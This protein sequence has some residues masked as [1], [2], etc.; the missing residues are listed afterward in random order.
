[1]PTNTTNRRGKWLTRPVFML[2]AGLGFLWSAWLSTR[3]LPPKITDGTRSIRPGVA[4]RT[5]IDKTGPWRIQIVEI[6]LKQPDLHIESARATDYFYGR[7]KLTSI[8]RRKSDNTRYVVVALNGDYFNLETGE[9]QNNNIIGGTFVKAFASPGYHPE[10]V[11]VPNSQFA[12]TRD[13]RP[14]IDQFVFSGRVLW[15]DGTA[16]QLSGVNTIPRRG[17]ISLFN[18]FTDGATP[19]ASEDTSVAGIRLQIVRRR[20]DTLICVGIGSIQQGGNLPIPSRGMVLAAYK[21]WRANLDTSYS[22]GDSVRIVLGM[23]PGGKDISE[24]I[25]GWPRIVRNGKSVFEMAGFPEN[26]DAS[27]FVKRHPRSG[28]GF[29]RDSTVL[30]LFAVDGRQESSAGMSLPEFARLMISV[31]VYEG[32]NLDGGGSTT[33]VIN[34]DIVNSPSDPTGERPIGNCL[35]L[36]A[37]HGGT[38]TSVVNS[39]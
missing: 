12:I 1:M 36:V 14:L 30:Y 13:R 27:I 33:M 18:E 22:A 34:G 7:E 6:N 32:L 37:E 21:Q 17:G 2:I 29:S 23:Q 28:V 16:S 20:S 26:P 15:E 24:L 8:V 3:P 10:Y 35:L 31:G 25:G 19:G 5:I 4:H 9:V 38:T 39:Q 11:D